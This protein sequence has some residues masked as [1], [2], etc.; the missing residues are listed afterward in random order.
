MMAMEYIH[1]LIK[2][3]QHA[4]NN[5]NKEDHKLTVLDIQKGL[6]ELDSVQHDLEAAKCLLR[7]ELK[8]RRGD[9]VEED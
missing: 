9:Y 1:R 5:I 8:T 2:S 6:G 4:I 3:G 7:E